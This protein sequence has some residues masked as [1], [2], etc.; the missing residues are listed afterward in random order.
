MAIA[1]DEVA[2]PEA[3]AAPAVAPAPVVEAAPEPVIAAAPGPA[4]A[5]VAEEKPAYAGPVI[6]PPLPPE[7]EPVRRQVKPRAPKPEP[8]PTEVKGIAIPSGAVKAITSSVDG[9]QLTITLGLAA[10]ATVLRAFTL[11]KPDRIALDVKGALPKKSY[12]INGSGE[13]VRARIGR[14]SG[15]TRVVLDL[16]RSPGKPTVSGNAITLPLK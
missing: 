3:V 14:I 1:S 8:T 7:P 9:S 2:V 15:G 11:A 16:S 5:P 12:V 4:P 6:V 10:N 13:L